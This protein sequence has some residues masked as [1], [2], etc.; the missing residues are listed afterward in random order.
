MSRISKTEL[1]RKISAAN[2]QSQATVKATVDALLDEIHQSV[3]NGDDV[4]LV[5]FGT[6]KLKRSAARQG[7]RPGT[8]DKIT[9]PASTRVTFKASKTKSS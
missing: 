1:V 4:N 6:F 5:G 2:G 7:V 9:I 3:H 8:S